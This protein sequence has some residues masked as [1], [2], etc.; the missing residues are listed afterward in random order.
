MEKEKWL[1]LATSET[2]ANRK[3]ALDL[4]P[5]LA[6]EIQRELI[7][8]FFFNPNFLIKKKIYDHL[9]AESRQVIDEVVGEVAPSVFV[10]NK[11]FQKYIYEQ[12]KKS[13]AL[14]H[15]LTLVL[16]YKKTTKES[17]TK[18]RTIMGKIKK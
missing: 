13:E 12:M 3:L 1:S 17:L 18:A 7:F 4:V 6:S 10:E 14:P 11:G 15:Y 2:D 16:N 5:V 9:T 8:W